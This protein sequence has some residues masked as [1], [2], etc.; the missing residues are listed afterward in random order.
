MKRARPRPV[1]KRAIAG[2]AQSGEPEPRNL[3]R[4][5]GVLR[6][7]LSA[8]TRVLPKS[9]QSTSKT[10]P[11]R[12]S[13]TDAKYHVAAYLAARA[14]VRAYIIHARWMLGNPRNH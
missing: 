6:S 7:T 12:E 5:K 11:G 2:G 3:D 13:P 4:R 14:A 9:P 10:P 8:A 1:V